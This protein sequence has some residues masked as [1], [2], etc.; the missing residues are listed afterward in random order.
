M[1]FPI[2]CLNGHNH[3]RNLLRKILRT[4]NWQH[5]KLND[6]NQEFSGSLHRRGLKYEP[7]NMAQML[8][9]LG[10]AVMVEISA[11]RKKILEYKYV[12]TAKVTVNQ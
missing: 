9:A 3:K 1:V 2:F 8:K 10:N 5:C 6:N 11:L 7:W 12:S 4:Q